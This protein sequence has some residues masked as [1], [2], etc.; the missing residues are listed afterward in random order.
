MWE[1][2][3]VLRTI[4]ED[5]DT[6]C[7]DVRGLR[8]IYGTGPAAVEALRGVDLQIPEREL[9]VILG[10]SGSGKSTF[11]NIIGGLDQATAGEVLFR[12]SD[13]SG[14]SSAE[15]T[16]YR[17]RHVGFVF[18]FYNLMPSLTAWENVALITEIAE[19]PLAPAD[20]LALVG[21]GDRMDHFP[22]QLSGGEQQRVAIARAVAK[23]PT[24]M[25]CDEPTGALDSATGVKVLEALVDVNHSI[26]ATTL[27]ITHNASVAEIA[28]RVVVFA[29][30]KVRETRVNPAP[31]SP[32]N[33]TW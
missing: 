13:L 3:H 29:D 25:L 23:Q 24:V 8:R 17:R 21:L 1:S 28:D 5:P 27:I 7:F 4:S 9:V 32:R 16:E 14:A 33:I 2:H 10:A 22:A 11:L 20:A 31:I 18:Q 12:G 26:G 6:A 19:A 30:G 15:L